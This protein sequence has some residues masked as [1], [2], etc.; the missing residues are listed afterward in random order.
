MLELFSPIRSFIF[1]VGGVL[2]TN[3]AAIGENGIPHFQ[4][5]IKDTVA[6][7]LAIAKGYNIVLISDGENVG[8]QKYYQ[9]LGIKELYPVVKNKADFFAGLNIDKQTALYMADDMPDYKAMQMSAL[10]C[11]PNDA[12][13]EIR[14]VAKYISPVKGGEGCVRDVIEKVLKLNGDWFI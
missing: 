1:D 14:A 5:N 11:C 6:L 10:P 13:N 3:T 12:V 4:V 9:S 8:L 2:T 7:K